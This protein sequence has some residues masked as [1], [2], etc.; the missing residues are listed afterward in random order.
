MFFMEKIFSDD[1]KKVTLED[2]HV[3]AL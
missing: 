2:G 3:L 1:K